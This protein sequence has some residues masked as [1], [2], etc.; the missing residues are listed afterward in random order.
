MNRFG[1][2]GRKKAAAAQTSETVG[3]DK[4]KRVRFYFASQWQLIWWR[5]RQ[6]RL[7][8]TAAPVLAV[9]YLFA[10]FCE[11]VTPY[12]VLKDFPA[13]KL[14]PP[15]KIHWISKEGKFQ[16]YVYGIK[17]ALDQATFRRVYVEDESQVYPVQFLVRG[18][19]Y[20]LWGLFPSDRHLI[21]VREGGQIFLFG[22]DRLGR[23]LFS[24][25]IYG[26][27]VSLTIGLVG[28]FLSFVLGLTIGGV[29]GYFG[30]SVDSFIQR[31]I[32]LLV[33]VPHLPLWMT[34]AA[35]LPRTWSN[36]QTYFAITVIL[37]IV[38]WAGLAR[39]VRGKLLA[40]REEDFTMA[41]RVSGASEWRIIT[42]HLLPLFL[43]Y[44][45]VSITLSIPGMILGETALSFIG[46]GMQPPAV[47]WGTLLQDAMRVAAV[48]HS[49][50]MLLPCVFVIVTV[51][52][53]N[54]LGDGLRDAAD[55]YSVR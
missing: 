3:V 16:P 18:E 14:A 43:S 25:V 49:P 20:R 15:S 47:S 40:L 35:A 39:V 9:M 4:R 5:F 41:A 17:G 19:R 12:T 32:D 45:I 44:V 54:F 36:V 21:G 53:F 22:T 30:G 42:K 34:L 38:G 11:F 27:R 23:D 7:S 55:P 52:M 51:L 29:S 31:T 6:H 46:L 13:Y 26:S 37:S 48:A 8:M 10:V 1:L 50:W 24:R 33:S 28:V 2:I